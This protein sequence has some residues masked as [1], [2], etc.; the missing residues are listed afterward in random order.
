LHLIKLIPILE[1]QSTVHRCFAFKRFGSKPFESVN[2]SGTPGF[3]IAANGEN[4]CH[5]MR[6]FILRAY[7]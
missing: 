4:E 6:F 7:S 3:R 5:L 1:L 2:L